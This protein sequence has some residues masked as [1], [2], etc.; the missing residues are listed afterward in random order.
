MKC[1]I[2]EREKKERN[3]K[4]LHQ[5]LALGGHREYCSQ[6]DSEE[7]VFLPPP[8]HLCSCTF[9][10][11]H[12][13][14]TERGRKTLSQEWTSMAKFGLVHSE[15]TRQPPLH[16]AMGRSFRKLHKRCR[17]YTLTSQEDRRRRKPSETADGNVQ[18]CPNSTIIT[19]TITT[20]NSHHHH[21]LT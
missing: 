11:S 15:L 4:W 21:S 12:V 16:T 20:I 8:S 10:F 14:R 9:M 6:E 1:K 7:E 19:I 13:A 17:E 18:C 3:D 5:L 2:A